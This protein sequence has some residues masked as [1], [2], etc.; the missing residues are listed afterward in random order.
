MTRISLEAK[1][2]EDKNIDKIIIRVLNKSSKP[3]LLANITNKA[4]II[5]ASDKSLYRVSVNQVE[6]RLLELRKNNI[7]DSNGYGSSRYFK[8]K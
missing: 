4:N 8:K 6:A 2:M 7:I 3:L 1:T 5:L